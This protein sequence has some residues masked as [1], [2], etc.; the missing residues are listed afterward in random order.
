MRERVE[1][2]ES[3]MH[4]GGPE[5]L[6]TIRRLQ[7]EAKAEGLWALGHPKELG[8]GGL[9]FMDYVYVNEV[10]GRSEFGQIALGHLHAA[11]L[12]HAPQVRVGRSGVT[13]TST[14]SSR[15]R[16]RRASP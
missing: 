2:A 4:E 3:Q 15:P 5:A 8:G 1:P 13:A 16:C 12:A 6:D 9:P 7:A 14:A 10:Q 11:G